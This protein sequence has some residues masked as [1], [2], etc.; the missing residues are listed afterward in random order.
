[1]RALVRG[2]RPPEEGRLLACKVGGSTMRG[3][4]LSGSGEGRLRNPLKYWS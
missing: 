3:A 2:L 1:M 4:G